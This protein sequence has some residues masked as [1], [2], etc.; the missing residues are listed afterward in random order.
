[1]TS[2][3][4]A[5]QLSPMNGEHAITWPTRKPADLSED[6]RAFRKAS[7]HSHKLDRDFFAPR[8]ERLY[9]TRDDAAAYEPSAR[10]LAA[11]AEL[12]SVGLTAYSPEYRVISHTRIHEHYTVAYGRGSQLIRVSVVHPELRDTPML[13]AVLVGADLEQN[14]SRAFEGITEL[15]VHARH[16][17]ATDSEHYASTSAMLRLLNPTPATFGGYGRVTLH[18]LLVEAHLYELG[19]DPIT[20]ADLDTRPGICDSCEDRHPFAPYL[21]PKVGDF[22]ARPAMVRVECL[23]IRPYSVQD[24]SA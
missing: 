5:L 7:M 24:V 2:N 9:V 21:P 10:D 18:G 6:A 8:A 23:P 19:I 16:E 4:T 17:T 15:A 13:L 20:Q 14:D 12:E 1:M 11:I 22:D 3:R